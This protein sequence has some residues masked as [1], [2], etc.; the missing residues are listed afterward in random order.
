MNLWRVGS[1]DSEPVEK[2]AHLTSSPRRFG[3]ETDAAG[4]AEGSV[5]RAP[6]WYCHS[7]RSPGTVHSELTLLTDSRA[8][9]SLL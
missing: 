9:S 7:V 1:E 5:P 8:Y 4:E 6:T 2:E 3:P